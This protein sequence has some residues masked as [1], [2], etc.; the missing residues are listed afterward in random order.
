M[1]PLFLQRILYLVFFAVG[2]LTAIWMNGWSGDTRREVVRRGTS[3]IVIVGLGAFLVLVVAFQVQNGSMVTPEWYL[4]MLLAVPF[5]ALGAAGR[6]LAYIRNE[7][8]KLHASD[9][10]IPS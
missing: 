8:L 4:W 9:A 1:P 5:A 2:W 3:R 6:T 7:L 10:L